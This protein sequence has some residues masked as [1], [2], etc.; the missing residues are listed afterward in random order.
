MLLV[1][2]LLLSIFETV[3]AEALRPLDAL[4]SAHGHLQLV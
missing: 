4:V 2:Y 3:L 1:L